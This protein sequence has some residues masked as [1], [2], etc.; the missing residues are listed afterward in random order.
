[1]LTRG[2]LF[3][4]YGQAAIDQFGI[5]LR[6]LAKVHP[7]WSVVVISDDPL[8]SIPYFMRYRVI[9][10]ACDDPGARWA[11]LH[12]DQLSPYDWTLYMDADT[13]VR[14]SISPI[15]DVLDS[16]WEIA[17]VPTGSKTRLSCMRH[18]FMDD[19]I[20]PMGLEERNA[21][22]AEVGYPFCGWQGGVMAFRKTERVHRFFKVWREEWGRWGDQD[23]PALARAYRRSPVLMFPLG[24]D[25]NGG[26]LVGHYHSMARRRGLRGSIAI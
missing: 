25:F 16:G 21:T 11:K 14:H 5:A 3:V 6:H 8:R 10:F 26:S 17:C 1:M 19:G 13:R 22:V 15:W 12:M 18:V 4:A 24:Q 9:P 23:Q 20:M 2:V 7:S